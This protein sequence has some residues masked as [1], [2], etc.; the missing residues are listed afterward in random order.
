[1]LRYSCYSCKFKGTKTGDIIIGDFWGADESKFPE[2]IGV[3]C[4]IVNS[5]KGLKL[6]KSCASLNTEKID[7]SDIA[8][9]NSALLYSVQKHKN[10]DIFYKQLRESNFGKVYFK[11]MYEF[12][13]P[14]FK[15][16]SNKAKIAVKKALN[17]A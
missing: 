1:M 9:N 6:L 16:L 8:N 14:A 4:V 13:E 12:Y 15:R 2:G 17:K 5:E 11:Y 3:S 7:L 10:R